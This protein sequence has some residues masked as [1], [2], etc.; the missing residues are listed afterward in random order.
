M[1]SRAGVL[2][3]KAAVNFHVSRDATNLELDQQD[4]RN[5]I[6]YVDDAHR[7]AEKFLDEEVAHDKKE[8]QRMRV[9]DILRRGGGQRTWSDTLKLSKLDRFEFK[10][11]IETLLDSGL[12]AVQKEGRTQWLVLQQLDQNENSPFTV[13]SSELVNSRSATHRNGYASGR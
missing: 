13:N 9:R 6:R 4:L 5:A 12:V 8:Q 10:G 1:R 2:V 3:L 7:K 11:A